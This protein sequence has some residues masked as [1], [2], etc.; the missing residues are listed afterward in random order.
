[1]HS[2]VILYNL[3]TENRTE[4]A[5]GFHNVGWTKWLNAKA[6]KKKAWFEQTVGVGQE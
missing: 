6:S 4:H 2:I 3:V 5:E 1:M